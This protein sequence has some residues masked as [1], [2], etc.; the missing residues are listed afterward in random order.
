MKRFCLSDLNLEQELSAREESQKCLRVQMVALREIEARHHI[1]ALRNILLLV[2]IIGLGLGWRGLAAATPPVRDSMPHAIASIIA[3]FP[4]PP[5]DRPQFPDRVFNIQ[6]H[7]AVAG[8]QTKNTEAIAKAIADAARSGGGTVLVPA[9]TWLTG[10]IHLDNNI[11]LQLDEGAVLLFSQNFDDYLPAVLSRHEGMDCLK[12]SSFVYA[13]GKTN[14]A[15][16]GQGTLE[17]QGKPWWV[18]EKELRALDSKTLQQLADENAP[19][20][21]RIVHLRPAFFQPIHCRNVL[22]EGVTFRFGAFWTIQPTYCENVIVRGVKIVT[23]GDYGHTPNG[24][25]VNPDSCRNVLIEYCDLETGDDCI[26]LKSGRAAD[27]LRVATPLENVVVRHCRMGQ[28]HGG[29]VVGSETSG[30]IRN[31]YAHDCAFSGTDRGVRIKTA[32]GR[33]AAIE[34]L[35]FENLTMGEIMKEAILLHMLRYTPRLPVF[36]VTETTPR[37]RN[38]HF[39]NITCEQAGGDAIQMVGLPELPMSD[40][41]FANIA[42]KSATGVNCTDARNVLFKEV[43]IQPLKGPV[44]DITDSSSITLENL[45]LPERAALLLKVSGPSAQNIRLRETDLTNATK[46]LELGADV[47]PGAVEIQKPRSNSSEL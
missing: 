33:G 5:L 24:D 46:V 12:Y 45:R 13:N 19:V 8:G 28:G 21:Q 32:R 18:S 26:T 17:G 40:I 11:N 3:P 35:W 31:V 38:I 7:G 22:V 20:E 44:F 37:L 43:G 14:I 27:G 47:N 42:I 16:T 15:I 6:D 10:A 41:Q 4:M 29:I 9:G 25:G 23:A 34:N 2:T 1:R 36:P 30:G 39:R